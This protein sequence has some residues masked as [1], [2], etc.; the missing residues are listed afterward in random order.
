MSFSID[1]LTKNIYNRDGTITCDISDRIF[2]NKKEYLK[3]Y[4][5]DDYWD[6]LNEKNKPFKKLI[7]KNNLL[8]GELINKLENEKNKN[9]KKQINS[10]INELLQTNK[11]IYDTKIY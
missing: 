9:E 10:K 4:N 1:S 5:S 11:K 8:V 6:L 7:E 2:K 3:W